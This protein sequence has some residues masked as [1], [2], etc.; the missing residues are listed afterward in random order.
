[1]R[2]A[3]NTR[4]IE[5]SIVTI[6]ESGV[7]PSVLT[8]SVPMVTATAVEKRNGP[9]MLQIAVENTARIGE[10]AFVATTVAIECEASLSPFTKYNA[11]AKILPNSMKRSKPIMYYA[12]RYQ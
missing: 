8:I 10:S 5:V 6:N 2:V 4:K 7:S 12:S 3:T 9:I 11:R 1:M